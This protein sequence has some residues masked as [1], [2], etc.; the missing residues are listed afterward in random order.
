LL[1]CCAECDRA[2]SACTFSKP[3]I[4]RIYFYYACV[5]GTYHKCEI[6]SARKH[7]KAEEVETRVWE[8][9]SR[10]LKDMSVC[11]PAWLT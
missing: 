9:V 6:C 1:R 8:V 5:A 10:E 3:K 2:M 11:V 7:H 4:E